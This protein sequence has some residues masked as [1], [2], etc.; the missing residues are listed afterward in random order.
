[1]TH[2]TSSIMADI[3]RAVNADRTNDI[4]IVAGPS[5]GTDGAIQALATVPAMGAGET[6]YRVIVAPVDAP[7]SIGGVPVQQHFAEAVHG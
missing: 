5:N 3:R 7:I 2:Y 4:T 1:M 6:R